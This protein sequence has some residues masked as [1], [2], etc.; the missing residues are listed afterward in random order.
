MDLTK[1]PGIRTGIAQRLFGEI[2]PDLTEFRSA[3]AFASRMGLCPD[4]GISGGKV[5]RVGTRRVKCRAATALRMA[6][7]SLHHSKSAPGDFYQQMRAKLGPPKTITSAAHNSLASSSIWFRPGRSSMIHDSQPTNSGTS[8]A[9]SQAPGQGPRS[10]V[11]TRPRRS[12]D[13]SFRA[14]FPHSR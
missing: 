14:S 6:A 10:G 7:R 3:S 12:G 4:N 5:L 2:G 13:G 8:N 11:P 1:I 9:R